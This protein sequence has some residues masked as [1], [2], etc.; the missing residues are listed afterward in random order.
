V[1][2]LDSL[3]LRERQRYVLDGA[4]ES[5]VADCGTPALDEHDL[6]RVVG[7]PGA[8]DDLLRAC[9]IAV[10]PTRIAQLLLSD[11]AAED[12]DES[13]EHEPAER[14]GLPMSSAPAP[15]SGGE[16]V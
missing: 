15:C 10:H 9:G 14:G 16:I 13:D 7:K 5:W 8:V 11:E 6:G 1:H 12:E 4:L 2:P 3:H